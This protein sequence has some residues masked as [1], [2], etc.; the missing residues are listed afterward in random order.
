V[1]TGRYSRLHDPARHPCTIL[2]APGSSPAWH[3]RS[4]TRV[5]DESVVCYRPGMRAGRAR[6]PGRRMRRIARRCAAGYIANVVVQCVAPTG[7]MTI[8]RQGR[9]ADTHRRQA[10]ST[11]DDSVPVGLARDERAVCCRGGTR[12]G[13]PRSD[14]PREAACSRS[15]AH[16]CGGDSR[17]RVDGNTCQFAGTEGP[18]GKSVLHLGICGLDAVRS[19]RLSVLGAL[20]RLLRRVLTCGQSPVVAVDVSAVLLYTRHWGV[21]T[22]TLND[23]NRDGSLRC[24]GR[25]IFV[26]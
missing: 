24:D 26:G 21:G 20:K 10:P 5:R 18:L 9:V 8:R 7:R 15:S 16:S 14:D 19:A 4:R 22:M 13:R 3:A 1:Q 25:E 6:K 2:G 12:A 23:E 17:P 11:A